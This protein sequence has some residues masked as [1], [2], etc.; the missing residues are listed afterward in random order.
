MYIPIDC[1]FP[2]LESEE[3]GEISRLMIS[4]DALSI[5]SS[6]RKL[7]ETESE[8]LPRRRTSHRKIADF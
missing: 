4:A 7:K 8:S 3:D 1:C 6:V 5:R 2:P